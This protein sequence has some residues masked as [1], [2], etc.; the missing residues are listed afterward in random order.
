MRLAD[1]TRAR[2]AVVVAVAVG[3]VLVA[4][5]PVLLKPYALFLAT[6]CAITA[7]IA[8]S[9]GV[10]TGRA[11]MMSLCQLSFG[12]VGAWSVA[13]LNLHGWQL[14]TPI[15]VLLGGVAALP[16]GV[17]LALPA[18]RVR[19]IN[20]AI[21]TLGFAAFAEVFFSQNDLPGTNEGLFFPRSSAFLSDE[22]FYYMTC[23]MVLVAMVVDRKSTR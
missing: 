11:G 2:A 9:L 18:L 6:T 1:L 16:I 22:S 19:G 13:Y 4:I 12:A 5:L 3:L 17:L 10:V 8:M 23:A 14:P 20:F 15:M 7:V 21:I